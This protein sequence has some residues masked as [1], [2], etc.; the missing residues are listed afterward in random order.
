MSIFLKNKTF[1]RMLIGGWFSS[2][3][4]TLFYLSFI[5]YVTGYE[6][7]KTAV[8]FITISETIPQVTMLVTGVLADFQ[9]N[10]LRKYLTISFIKCV[11]YVFV[12]LLLFQTSQKDFGLLTVA[13]ICIINLV[14]DSLSYFSGAMLT[15]LYMR[16]IA[17]DMT[18]AMGFRQATGNLVRVLGN[19]L[20]GVLIGAMSIASIAS[21]NALTFFVV[22]LIY[23]WLKQPLSR[24]EKEENNPKALTLENTADHLKESLKC[25]WELKDVLRLLLIASVS[26]III[27]LAMPLSAI[28]LVEYPFLSLKSGQSL[29]LLSIL[30]TAGLILGSFVSGRLEKS[31]TNK[32]L[33]YVETLA[34]LII[35]GGFLLNEFL[36]VLIGCFISALAMGAM[37]PRFQK[38][39]FNLIPESKMGTIQSAI[40]LVDILLPSILTMIFVAIATS[41]GMVWVCLGLGSLVL[42]S[43]YCLK[44]T[45]SS[46][47]S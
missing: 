28:S 41:F 42:I 3:G 14:S 34:P 43:L 23:L 18:E 20:G 11:L 27:G 31:L 25:L 35:L 45:T 40:S 22:Y 8:L 9:K 5:N 44:N 29:A 16:L 26:S 21:F 7:A 15:P 37:Q 32:T 13:I 2:L 33:L 17:D 24:L 30:L 1:R 6:F 38:V 4:D 12:A 36:F 46:E 39:V 10:R 47:F 19:L